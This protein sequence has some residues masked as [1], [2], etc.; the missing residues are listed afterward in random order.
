MNSNSGGMDATCFGRMLMHYLLR[1]QELEEPDGVRPRFGH[2]EGGGRCGAD[3][4]WAK[5]GS[6]DQ[7]RDNGAGYGDRLLALVMLTSR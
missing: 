3:A 6:L 1:V 5:L 2:A 7:C 4:F